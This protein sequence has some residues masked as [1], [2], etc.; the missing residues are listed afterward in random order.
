MISL[1]QKFE[2]Q[3]QHFFNLYLESGDETNLYQ[4]KKWSDEVLAYGISPD[5]VVA[6]HRKALLSQSTK[7]SNSMVLAL[8]ILMTVMITYGTDFRQSLMIKEKQMELQ[9]EIKKA[10]KIQRKLLETKVPQTD[11]LEIGICHQP[12]HQLSGD[13]YHFNENNG[14]ISVCLADVIGKGV[15]AALIMSMLKY[16]MLNT[17]DT[18]KSVNSLLSYLNDVT[19]EHLSENM[20]VTMF[21]GVYDKLNGSFKYSSAGHEIGFFYQAETG[22]SQDLYAKGLILGIQK[23]EV[24]REYEQML[25]IGDIIIILSDGVTETRVADGFIERSELKRLINKYHC[26]P[27]Q[28]IVDQVYHSLA[29]LQDFKLYDDFTLIVLK[30]VR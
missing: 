5:E 28:A 17:P 15:P 2:Q 21:L 3:Y 6:I 10:S 23:E 9:T 22:K 30:R 26:L 16:A 24:Y 12:A 4:L 18:I 27:A 29:A 8:E 11:Y 1:K 20:F 19:V 25:Q 13:L 14:G 7:V